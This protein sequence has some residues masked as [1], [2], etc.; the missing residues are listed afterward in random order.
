M[1]I[2]QKGNVIYN[3]GEVFAVMQTEQDARTLVSIMHDLEYYN[4]NYYDPALKEAAEKFREIQ[5]SNP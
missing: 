1:K 4:I 2:E 5:K 3:N